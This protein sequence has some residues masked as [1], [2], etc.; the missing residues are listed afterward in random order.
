[1]SCV[2]RLFRILMKNIHH[3]M[4]TKDIAPRLEEWMMVCYV[5]CCFASSV[6][7]KNPGRLT[8]YSLHVEKK[9]QP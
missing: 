7:P 5:V 9:K 8:F 3:K 6:G 4:S 2:L 1:M